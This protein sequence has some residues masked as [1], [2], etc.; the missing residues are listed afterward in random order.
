M[1]SILI[2][3]G[4]G[5]FGN[6]FTER[7]LKD[8]LAERV[9]IY[10]RGEH[11]QSTM[12]HRFRDSRLRFFIGDVRD[13][14][15]LIRAMDGCDVVVH[16]AA[17]KDITTGHYNPDEVIKTNVMGS[18]DV[19]R[20]AQETGVK[21]VVGLSSDKAYQ[22][23]SIYGHT[24]AA[25]ECLFLASNHTSGKTG[26]HF[27]ITRY[28]NIFASQGS[29]VPRWKANQS[30]GAP[31]EITDPDCTR[32]FMWI[33][34]AV[35]LVLDTLKK[36]PTKPAI[37]YLPAYRLGDLAHA[38]DIKPVEIGLGEHEKRHESMDE[39]VQQ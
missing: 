31:C 25:M 26:P 32:F 14:D 1:K 8:N 30:A 6:A 39:F 27:S 20:A 15:R 24:K 3:G 28:G 37:P 35:D 10:S 13:R 17:L 34:E 22:P 4:T 38:M 11:A 5:T 12:R 7:L 29:V 16:A 23:I 36:M 33:E 21:K 9:C 2:T 19:V 18:L